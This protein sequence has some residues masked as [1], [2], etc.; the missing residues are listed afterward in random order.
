MLFFI[1]MGPG[2]ICRLCKGNRF[3]MLRHNQCAQRV[4]RYN[5]SFMVVQTA[6]YSVKMHYHVVFIGMAVV[7][8]ATSEVCPARCTCGQL[9]MGYHVTVNCSYQQRSDVPSDFPI[10]TEY[11][12]FQGNNIAIF[13]FPSLSKLRKLD[14]QGNKLRVIMV[15]SFRHLPALETLILSDNSITYL[16]AGAF[17]GMPALRHL[18]LERNSINDLQPALFSD[19]KLETLW[20]TSNRLKTIRADSFED[21]TVVNLNLSANPIENPHV[22]AFA[23]LKASLKRFICNYNLEQ[24]KFGA[25]AFRGV[26][27]TELSLTYSRLHDDTSFLEHVNTIRLDLSGNRLPLSSLNLHNYT[28]LSNV[29]YL[30]LVDMSL[31]AISSELLPNSSALR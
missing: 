13:T 16:D 19:L 4:T 25:A 10:D 21:S 9:S 3:A 22:N 29:Q 8:I 17:R 31:T 5:Y 18:D 26:N 14:M 12:M 24:L 11:V 27:L 23:P 6:T 1:F 20:L 28:S 30:R 7:R 15:N 2:L